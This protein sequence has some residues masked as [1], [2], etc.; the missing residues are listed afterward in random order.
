MIKLD[1]AVCYLSLQPN[2]TSSSQRSLDGIRVRIILSSFGL[3]RSVIVNAWSLIV[4]INPEERAL[5][6]KIKKSNQKDSVVIKVS[7]M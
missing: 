4:N 6:R 7:K 2:S 3:R 5:V 1:Q